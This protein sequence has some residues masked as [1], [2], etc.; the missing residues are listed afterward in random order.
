MNKTKIPFF[1]TII[2]AYRF[3]S[4]QSR[5]FINLALL[6]VVVLAILD[7]LVAVSLPDGGD[8]GGTA[9]TGGSVIGGLVGIILNIG[10]GVMFA[11]AWHRRFLVPQEGASV[12]R[13]YRWRARHSKFL[14]VSIAI[15]LLVLLAALIPIL[16]GVLL[17]PVGVILFVGAILIA[18]LMSARLSM[19][20]PAI[21]VDDLMNFNQAWELAHGNAWR[22]FGAFVLAA[23][24]I[25][26]AT[27]I[28][29]LVLGGVLGSDPGAPGLFVSAFVNEFFAFAAAAIGVTV[30]SE[31]YRIVG[32]HGAVAATPPPFQQPGA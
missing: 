31:A 10:A 25:G 1:E 3:L 2:L 23:I 24:P 22:I 20:L 21:A 4:D 18:G 27:S 14:F 12:Y 5:D 19:L 30:L 13:A 7:T 29:N 8:A 16:V 32:K 28:A 15:G 11:V 17:G 6:P 26:L 9:T